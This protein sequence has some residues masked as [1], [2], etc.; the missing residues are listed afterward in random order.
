MTDMVEFKAT[1]LSK[2]A[3]PVWAAASEDP[4]LVRHRHRDQ[5]YVIMTKERFDEL[6]NE[7]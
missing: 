6:V 5:D 7:G 2:D 3:R 1:E 4:I